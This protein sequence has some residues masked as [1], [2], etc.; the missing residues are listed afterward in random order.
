MLIVLINSSSLLPF[1]WGIAQ[2]PFIFN[3]AFALG[4]G[5]EAVARDGARLL[6]YVLCAVPQKRL[7]GPVWL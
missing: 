2:L 4:P 3:R 7:L 6:P 5:G 1:P